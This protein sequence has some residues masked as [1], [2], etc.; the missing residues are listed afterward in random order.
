SRAR[1]PRPSARTRQQYRERTR[2]PSLRG[3]VLVCR[4]EERVRDAQRRRRLVRVGVMGA[5][6]EFRRGIDRRRFTSSTS[7]FLHVACTFKT[8]SLLRV[9][10]LST[11]PWRSRG[12]CS[13]A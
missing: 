1:T 11:V 8:V 9:P 12:P 7:I 5:G 4:T 2:S 3:F 10:V 6:G 13:S